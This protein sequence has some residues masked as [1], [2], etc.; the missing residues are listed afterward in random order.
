[1]EAGAIASLSFS[2]L[3][4]ARPC[5]PSV[6]L[7]YSTT[8][9]Q[10]SHFAAKWSNLHLTPHSQTSTNSAA[11]L[12]DLSQALLTRSPDWHKWQSLFVLPNSNPY[13]FS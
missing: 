13:S 4:F 6:R 8:L 2:R 11:S 5:R 7:S 3:T 9:V 12:T 1:M 10:S